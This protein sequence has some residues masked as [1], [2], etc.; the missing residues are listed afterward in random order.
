[1]FGQ[2]RA[3]ADD[4]A[5]PLRL[6]AQAGGYLLL[7]GTQ[8]RGLFAP[9]RIVPEVKALLTD[10]LARRTPRG[11]FLLHAALLSHARRGLLISGP[12]GAGKTT[13]TLALAAR[14]LGYGSDDIVRVRGADFAGVPFAPASKSG[15]W[16]LVW[17]HV[18]AVAGLETHLRADGQA[19]RYVPVHGFGSGEVDALGWGAVAGPARGRGGGAGCGRA[20]GGADRAAGRGVLARPFAVR[21]RA[22]GARRGALGRAVP[23]AGLQRP[24]GGDRGG[25]GVGRGRCVGAGR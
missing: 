6:V 4:A 2:F 16:S 13:L 22:A 21:E 17:D 9:E 11:A 12:P 24:G 19:V 14:G 23:P 18:R 8:P 15:G 5:L 3:E 10:H 20:A 25:L 1:V 7:V